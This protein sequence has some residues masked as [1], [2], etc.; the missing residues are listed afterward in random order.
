MKPKKIKHAYVDADLLIF[1]AASSAQQIEY[2]FVDEEGNEVGS[3]SKAKSTKNWLEEC[4]I[5]G[6]DVEFGYEGDITKLVRKERLHI[7][8]FQEAVKTYKKLL[9][10]W[11]KQSGADT[12]TCYVSKKTGLENFRHKLSLRKP[13]KGNR[14][15]AA[16][17]YHLD[18]LRKY[19]LTMP[20]HKRSTGDVET[21][22]IVC[23]LSQRKPTNVLIQNEKD[24][25]QC[26]GCWVYYPDYHDVPVWSDPDTLGYIEE[27]S[28]KLTG[29]GHL[30]LLGQLI[31][32]D[33]ADN[34]SGI[35][36]V[37]KT[38]AHETLAPFNNQP[39]DQLYDAVSE[40]CEL[41]YKKYGLAYDYVNKD[42]ERAVGSWKDFIMETLNLAYMRKG[43]DDLVPQPYT[44]MINQWEKDNKL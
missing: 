10:R 3:F 2:Y 24:G 9:M 31:T 5:M 20:N 25:L 12:Y 11:L 13:Y 26:V 35:D 18:Q 8:E 15:E 38:K 22:D 37:G 27:T 28:L 36:R 19:V 6:A 21:D 39:V 14:K 17:P 40:V 30:F 34:Y 43:R 1:P 42:G 16:K 23:G 4:E 32:G 33:S 29:L 7:G 44:D 41:Y